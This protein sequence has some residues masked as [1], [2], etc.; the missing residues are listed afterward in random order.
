MFP[1]DPTENR[2]FLW[3]AIV[4]SLPFD[5]ALRRIVTTTVNYFLLNSVPFPKLQ[6][7]SLLGR[8]MVEASR[9]LHGIYSR[10][11]A[12]DF[13][14]AAELRAFIDIAVQTAYG[15]VFRDLELMLCDFPLLD[16]GQ[17]PIDGEERSTV[18]RDFLLFHASMRFK[19]RSGQYADRLRAAREVGA[20]PYIPS[21]FTAVEVDNASEASDE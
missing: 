13:W 15:L 8:R 10:T 18:T 3:L 7:D 5:W 14:R 9:K 12:E 4:N 17:P 19:E 6:P 2:L 21:E 16:R 11:Y 1:N 20:V